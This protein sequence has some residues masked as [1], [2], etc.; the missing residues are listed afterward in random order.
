M[1]FIM[2]GKN[3]S[4][5]AKPVKNNSKCDANLYKLISDTLRKLIPINNS[6]ITS[7]SKIT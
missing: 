4:K 3:L 2:H 1:I 5:I 7:D 6:I